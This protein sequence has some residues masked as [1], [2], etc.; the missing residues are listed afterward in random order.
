MED[1]YFLKKTCTKDLY[2]HV[3]TCGAL[4][5]NQSVF[6]KYLCQVIFISLGK[7]F[8]T[9][10]LLTSMVGSSLLGGAVLRIVGCLAASAH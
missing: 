4:D 3:Y 10:A 8:T 6:Y 9:S 5:T 7:C 1:T 2:F